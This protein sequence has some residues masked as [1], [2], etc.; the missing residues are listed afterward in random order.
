[1][2]RRRALPHLELGTKV[3]LDL[4][5]D[6]I[7]GMGAEF[8]PEWTK[9]RTVYYPEILSSGINFTQGYWDFIAQ[10]DDYMHTNREL[11]LL[12]A[13]LKGE[14]LKA[15]FNLSAEV[16]LAVMEYGDGGPLGQLVEAIAAQGV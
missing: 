13:A 16:R 14:L 1:M 11:R 12:V 7:E 2:V 8:T 4:K 9:K 15:Q 5:F 3:G 6:I 10:T